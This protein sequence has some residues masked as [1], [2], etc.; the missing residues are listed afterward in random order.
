MPRTV[1]DTPLT[2]AFVD[3]GFGLK[4]QP[5]L[6]QQVLTDWD[7]L[8]DLCCG[9]MCRPERV[10]KDGPAVIPTRFAPYAGNPGVAHRCN[11]DAIARTA[12]IL[13]IEANKKTSVIPI[14]PPE[15]AAHI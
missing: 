10:N 4:G 8:S 7:H 13:D 2:L 3:S 14:T 11:A 1:Y 15:M 12:A 9:L 5:A 6:A